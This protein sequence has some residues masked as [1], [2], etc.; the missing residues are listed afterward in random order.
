MKLKYMN[1]ET[2]KMELIVCQQVVFKTDKNYV[3]CFLNEN[4]AIDY[5]IKVLKN[6]IVAI[7]D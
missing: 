4:D 3:L 6:D 1:Y 2:K 5:A 7:T